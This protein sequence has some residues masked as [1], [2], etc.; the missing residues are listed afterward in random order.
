MKFTLKFILTIKLCFYRININLN[1]LFVLS[2]GDMIMQKIPLGNTGT[3]VSELCLGTMYF[4]NRTDEETSRKLLDIYYEAGGRFLDTANKYATWVEV[5]DEPTSEELL[6]RWMKGRDNRDELFVATKLGFPYDDVSQS[7]DPNIIEAEVE[8]SLR[9][10]G[11]KKIDLLYAHVDDFGTPQEKVMEKFHQLIE[12][13]KV[14][15]I[16]ASNFLAWRLQSAN[17]IAEANDWTPYCCHQGRYSYLVPNRGSDFGGQ[18]PVTDEMVDYWQS[19]A[20]DFTMLAYSPLLS[21]CYGREDRSIPPEYASPENKV[22]MEIVKDI[23]RKKGLNGNQV[24]LAWMRQSDPPVIPLIAGSTEEQIR[25]NIHSADVKLS[26]EEMGR[27]NGV[28]GKL[29]D[30]R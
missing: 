11:T 24:V 7:L 26:D 20:S 16:G 23:A 8:K 15:Y 12:E 29:G 3:E 5:F 25:Q 17:M 22:R 19:K 14:R 4:G 1:V 27:L 10:L 9:K 21:G 28:G 30:L 2:R 18:V 6:G 13:G